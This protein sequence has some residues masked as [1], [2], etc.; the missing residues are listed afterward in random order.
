MLLGVAADAVACAVD[1]AV[2]VLSVVVDDGCW[3]LFCF[4]GSLFAEAL[5]ICKCSV[6]VCSHGC[7]VFVVR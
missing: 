5:T 3:L 4:V 6:Y 1:V 2:L 7:W